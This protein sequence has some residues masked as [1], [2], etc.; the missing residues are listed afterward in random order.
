[1]SMSESIFRTTVGLRFPLLLGFE[2]AAE[3]SSDYD[4]GAAEGKKYHDEALKF[5]VGYSW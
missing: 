4:G 2:A 3:V 5:R 1:A